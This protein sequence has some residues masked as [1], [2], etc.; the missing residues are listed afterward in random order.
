[1]SKRFDVQ[2]TPLPGLRLIRR[3]P[4]ADQRGYLERL[5]CEDELADLIG[6]RRIVQI[7]HTLTGRQGVVRGMHF[8]SPP[9]AEMK[10]VTCLRGS[11]FDVAV[12]VR[13]GLPTFLQWHAQVLSADNHCTFVIP[14]G[15]AHGFQTLSTDCEMLY[16]HTNAYSPAAEGGLNPRDPALAIE[17]PLE[18][19]DMSER[20]GSHPPVAEGFRGV[21][22]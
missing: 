1:M 12:D 8:Q 16:F 10:M 14:E 21:V 6:D 13:Q 22:L 5:F 4:L 17:W 20:D 11:V 15:Y 19:A 3:N 7:N 18:I 9:G 2:E